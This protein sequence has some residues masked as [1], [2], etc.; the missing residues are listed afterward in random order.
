MVA[1]QIQARGIDDPNVLRAMRKV[2]RHAFMPPAQ[3]PYAYA[4]EVYSI[5]IIPSL[6]EAAAEVLREL[7]YGNVFV[8]AGDGYYR[9]PEQGPF[10]A[11]IGTAAADRISPRLLEQLDPG[12]R[13]ILPQ[14]DLEGFMA[15]ILVTKG[16]QGRLSQ[17]EVLPVRFVPMTGRVPEPTDN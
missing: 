17:E 7:G 4:G 8:R 5:E 1:Q 10:D 14:R 9:W 13:M 16:A 3:R 12:G 11:I 15:L 6:A 2:P